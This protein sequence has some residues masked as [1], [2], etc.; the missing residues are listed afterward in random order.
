V[1][2]NGAAHRR[3]L[4][5]RAKGASLY[6]KLRQDKYPEGYQVLCFNC[7]FAKGTRESC[8]CKEITETVAE[9]LY[10]TTDGLTKMTEGARQLTTSQIVFIRGH[11]EL[12]LRELA[13]V[14]DVTDTTI[15]NARTYRT[16]KNVA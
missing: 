13:A 6:R 16:Y 7:N 8:P 2:G 15:F 11:P 12:S 5:G 4:D 3:S 10:E 14:F 9:A 1:Y